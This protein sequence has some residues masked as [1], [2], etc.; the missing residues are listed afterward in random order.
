MYFHTEKHDT[1]HRWPNVT[2]LPLVDCHLSTTGHCIILLG[3]ISHG[4]VIWA[5]V[6]MKFITECIHMHRHSQDFVCG[7]ALFY[8]PAKTPKN[9]LLLWL[10]VHFVSCGGALT[11]FSCKL[12]LKIFF[13]T[14]LGVQVHPLHPLATPMTQSIHHVTCHELPAL[15][16]TSSMKMR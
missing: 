6:S 16:N 7:G 2:D 4:S 3:L 12:G 14:A 10:G 15:A 1:R 5:S 13:F 11:H 9:W 8:H